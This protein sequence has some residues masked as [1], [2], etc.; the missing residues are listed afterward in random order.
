[1]KELD[2]IYCKFQN[3]EH[4]IYLCKAKGNGVHNSEA[5]EQAI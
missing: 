1:M 2:K 5:Y 3:L 4:Y